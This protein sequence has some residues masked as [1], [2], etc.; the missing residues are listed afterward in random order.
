MDKNERHAFA[1]PTRLRIRT[2]RRQRDESIRL[3][4]ERSVSA[5]TDVSQDAHGSS[6][7]QMP[8]LQIARSDYLELCDLT[9]KYRTPNPS[10]ALR[11]LER[12]LSRAVVVDDRRIPQTVATLRPQ[13]AFHH[14]ETKRDWVVTIGHP[15]DFLGREDAIS[16]LSPLGAAL[17]G[18]S[19][20]QWIDF[21]TA[22]ERS[23]RIGLVRVL[24]QPSRFRSARTA[25]RSP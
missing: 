20:G 8:D 6:G 13:V 2:Y 23:R 15:V 9:V 16:V 14:Q 4:H 10:S 18:L 22:D 1:N 11:F 3:D 12:E 5:A 25:G 17:I 21:H 7:S 24:S 19:E